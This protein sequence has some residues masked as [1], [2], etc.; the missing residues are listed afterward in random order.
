MYSIFY[1]PIQEKDFDLLEIDLLKSRILDIYRRNF[2]EQT[3][4]H[5]E[6]EIASELYSLIQERSKLTEK[7]IDVIWREMQVWHERL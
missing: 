5:H 7:Y 2:T 1:K 3:L 4:A 6:Y